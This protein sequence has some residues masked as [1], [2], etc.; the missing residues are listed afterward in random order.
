MKFFEKH[1]DMGLLLLRIGVGLG[2][3]L[4]HGLPKITGG[5]EM[6][7]RL[8]GAMGNL[9]ITFA[10]TFWGFMSSFAEFGGGILILLGLFTRPAAAF[11][12]FNMFVAVMS[13]F[14]RLD[15]WG[16]VITPIEL[17]SVFLGLIFLGA[18]KYSLDYLI[19]GRKK[20]DTLETMQNVNVTP[21]SKTGT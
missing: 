16:R 5:P 15:P 9:G 17:G 18:G 10:P 21:I 12:A 6:W 11:M 8:G 20:S 14:V 2:F 3:I 1:K 19:F 7:T 13:H 4:V